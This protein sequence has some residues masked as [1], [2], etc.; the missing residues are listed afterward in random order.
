MVGVSVSEVVSNWRKLNRWRTSGPKAFPEA[1]ALEAGRPASQNIESGVFIC[2]STLAAADLIEMRDW[3]AENAGRYTMHA[4]F[5]YEICVYR[6][7]K[8]MLGVQFDF[9]DWTDAFH[10]KLRWY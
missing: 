10:F 2:Q 5:E 6:V 7:E 1:D 9:E 3:L 8:E 4:R